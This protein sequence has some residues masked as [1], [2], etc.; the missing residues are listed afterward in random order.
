MGR[1]RRNYEAQLSTNPTSYAVR[2]NRN[3]PDEGVIISNMEESR[4]VTVCFIV[5][6]RLHHPDYFSPLGRKEDMLALGHSP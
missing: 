4:R 2:R 5:G 6:H 1:D 3:L